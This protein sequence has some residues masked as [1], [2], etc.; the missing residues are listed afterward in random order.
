MALLPMKS[1]GVLL[2]IYV[3]FF[4]GASKDAGTAEASLSP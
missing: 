3:A 1:E 4:L 2:F